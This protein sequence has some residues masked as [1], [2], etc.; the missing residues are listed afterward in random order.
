M[1]TIGNRVKKSEGETIIPSERKKETKRTR[2]NW[3]IVCVWQYIVI[4][5]HE[6]LSRYCSKYNSTVLNSQLCCKAAS[7]EVRNLSPSLQ[8]YTNWRHTDT[9]TQCHTHTMW[10]IFV[11][12]A[13]ALCLCI[14]VLFVLQL[15]RKCANEDN[16]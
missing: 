7:A 14:S 3:N 12:Y 11:R 2:S 13:Q 5:G 4:S 16:K 10:I 9:Q 6:L 15:Q 1:K 8:Q